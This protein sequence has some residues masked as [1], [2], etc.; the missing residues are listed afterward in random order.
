[1]LETIDQFRAAGLDLDVPVLEMSPF[2]H[3]AH[4]RDRLGTG[5]RLSVMIKV[6]RVLA[7]G[8]GVSLQPPCAMR[9]LHS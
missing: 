5:Q 8:F 6:L 9:S 4:E 3:K 2:V 1:L 7:E